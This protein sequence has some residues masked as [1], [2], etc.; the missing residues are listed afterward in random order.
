MNNSWNGEAY[1]E[2]FQ[3][4]HRYGEELIDLLTPVD[5][6]FVVDLGCGNGA[7]TQ[8]LFDKGFDVLGIDAS[9]NMLEKARVLH[10][11]LDFMQADACGF[12]LKEKAD[13]IFSNAVFH[14]IDDHRKLVKNIAENLKPGGELVFEF[15]GKGCAKTVHSAMEAAFEGVGLKY[16][17]GFNFCSIGEFAPLLEEHGFR[18]EYAALFERPTEQAGEDGLE[19][20]INMF[21]GAAFSGVDRD[22]KDLI[23]TRVGELCKPKLYAGGK[24]YIDYV[25][26]RMKA[27]KEFA[28]TQAQPV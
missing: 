13:A 26:I 4:V 22:V 6:G 27:V 3:F 12:K 14:W 11:E 5:G 2:K 8:K 1:T 24:W 10:P 19:D 21:L 28:V 20:W 18:V 17:N 7:L 15:G 9:E 16:A 23:M 25:R